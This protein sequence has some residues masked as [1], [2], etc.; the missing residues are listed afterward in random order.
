MWINLG[1]LTEDVIGILIKLL[2]SIYS[3]EVSSAVMAD[4]KFTWRWSLCLD[5]KTDSEIN[6]ARLESTF[7]VC[8]FCT[9]ILFLETL[10][11][12]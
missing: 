6:V 4:G 5:F 12:T 9:S 11:T 1:G 7:V 8:P 10:P 3:C 2:D